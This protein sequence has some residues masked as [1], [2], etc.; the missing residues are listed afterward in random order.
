MNQLSY[1]IWELGYLSFAREL[2]LVRDLFNL[3][4]AYKIE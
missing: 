2:K 1:V 3:Y 4:M